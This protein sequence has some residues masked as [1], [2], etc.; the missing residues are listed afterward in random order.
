MK[1]SLKVVHNKQAVEWRQC[2][3]CTA[4]CTALAVKELGKPYYCKCEHEAPSQCSIYEK[5]PPN[6][7]SFQC[8]WSTANAIGLGRE[9]GIGDRPDI[10][11]AI[12]NLEVHSGGT[13]VEVYLTKPNVNAERVAFL[14]DLMAEAL[15]AMAPDDPIIGI[16]LY[17]YGAEIPV[18]YPTDPKY[19][20]P[21]KGTRKLLS[22]DDFH[23]FYAGPDPNGQPVPPNS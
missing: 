23:Y 9:F 22:T 19:P 8:F 17:E 10:L 5:R 11:G 2:G 14:A 6:C 16:S 15:T 12:F 20:T 21:P 18:A 13:W 3:T 1:F 4:C 7:R